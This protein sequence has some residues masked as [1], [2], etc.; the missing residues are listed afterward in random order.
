VERARGLK[1]AGANLEERARELRHAFLNR[2]ADRLDASLIAIAHHADDQ[3]ETVLMRILRGAGAAG[4]AAMAEAGPGRLWRPLLTVTRATIMAYL[5]QI[6]AT[7]TTDSS[8]ASPRILR[9]RIRRELIPRLEREFAP[10]LAGRLT[11]LAGELRALDDFLTVAARAELARR[12]DGERL[13]LAGF[14]G[15]PPALAD[16]ILREEMRER[17]GGLRRISR[18]H[19]EMMRALCAGPNPSGHVVIPGGWRLRR[20]YGFAR[21]EQMES[22]AAALKPSIPIKL[23]LCGPTPVLAAGFTF[24]ARLIDCPPQEPIAIPRDATEAIFDADQLGGSLAVRSFRAGDRIAPQGMKGSRKVQDL[25][26]DRKIPRH[27]RASWP[28]VVVSEKI[29][30]IPAIARSRIALVVAAGEGTPATRKILHLRA[31]ST[32]PSEIL[33]LLENPAPC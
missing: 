5:A 2:V 27:L 17:L 30:W 20:E 15:L 11:E 32:T 13:A 29:L 21:L 12:R 1:A 28:I 8:N 24:D 3:A 33:S 16:A 10:G 14:G 31:V 26:V 23:R 7:W 18:D 19:I 9:N 4:L 6:G 22:K 25:F